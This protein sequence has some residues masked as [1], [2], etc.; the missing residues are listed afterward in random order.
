MID[1][2]DGERLRAGKPSRP[3]AT[4]STKRSA[5]CSDDATRQDETAGDQRLA[6]PNAPSGLLWVLVMRP[7]AL[8]RPLSGLPTHRSTFARTFACV[9]FIAAS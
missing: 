5:Y 9:L 7:S 2:R 6:Y 1:R 4:D 8:P 3:Q